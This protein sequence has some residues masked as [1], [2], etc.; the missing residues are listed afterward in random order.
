MIRVAGRVEMDIKQF[1]ETLS[2]TNDKHA[3]LMKYV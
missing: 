2:A 1:D 3:E